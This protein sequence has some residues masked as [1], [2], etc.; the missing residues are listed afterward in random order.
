MDEIGQMAID[1]FLS[2]GLGLVIAFAYARAYR[3]F[4]YSQSFVHTCVI[5][6]LLVDILVSIIVRADAIHSAALAF[7]LV[8]LLGLIRFRT[9]I[10]DTRE[11]SYVFLSIVS[12]VGIGSGNY[13]FAIG[14]CVTVLAALII[15]ERI[16]FG[17]VLCP[18][19]HVRITGQADKSSAYEEVL[20]SLSN[21]L[22]LVSVRHKEDGSVIY[23]YDLV[24]KT[25]NDLPA[26]VERL[27]ALGNTSEVR[28][29]RWKRSGSISDKSDD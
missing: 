7:S 14:S 10:R 5:T 6:V 24:A 1:L 27:L 28:M 4:Y 11:F 2:L 3:G 8:G 23:A 21:Q 25:R 22:D 15:F 17:A 29:H 20:T 26:V 12:G 16:N 19:V 18:S 13:I 9:V